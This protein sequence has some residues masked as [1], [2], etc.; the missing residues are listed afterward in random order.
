MSLT[1]SENRTYF[2]I[3]YR[4][5][6]EAKE[7]GCKFD[8]EKRKWYF[9]GTSEDKVKVLRWY[10]KLKMFLDVSFEE[11]DEAKKVGCLYDPDLQKWYVLSDDN[12][13]MNKLPKHWL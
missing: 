10:R 11:K 8:A 5:K 3:P 13:I 2:S 12:E 1:Q 6:D 4:K 9:S 7:Y